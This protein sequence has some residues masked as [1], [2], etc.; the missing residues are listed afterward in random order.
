MLLNQLVHDN[1]EV[2]K[3]VAKKAAVQGK[4][5]SIR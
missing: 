5:S 1:Y 3:P 2:K 4:V